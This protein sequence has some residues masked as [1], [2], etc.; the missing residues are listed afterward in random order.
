MLEFKAIEEQYIIAMAFELFAGVARYLVSNL[1]KLFNLI[2]YKRFI[3]G[4]KLK[5]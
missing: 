5:N 1:L 2:I 3:F 4:L